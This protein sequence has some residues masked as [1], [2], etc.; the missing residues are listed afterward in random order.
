[1]NKIKIL[2]VLFLIILSLVILFPEIV[3]SQ[4]FQDY[5]NAELYYLD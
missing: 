3:Q 1:M 4:Y 5:I 2:I